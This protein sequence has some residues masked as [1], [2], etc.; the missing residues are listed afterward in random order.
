M[1]LFCSDF[2]KFIE[3]VFLKVINK[4]NTFI[5]TYITDLII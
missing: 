5:L 1:K 3:E 2:E 4:K